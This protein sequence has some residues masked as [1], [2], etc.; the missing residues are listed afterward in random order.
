MHVQIIRKKQSDAGFMHALQ[1]RV[2]AD[3][4]NESAL[5]ALPEILRLLGQ[6]GLNTY[7]IHF[8][9]NQYGRFDIEISS[10]Y[11]V[12]EA[13]LLSLD[14]RKK[15]GRLHRLFYERAEDATELMDYDDFIH[16]LSIYT[17]QNISLDDKTLFGYAVRWYGLLETYQ[18]LHLE[19]VDT[20][21]VYHQI[22]KETDKHWISP[23]MSKKPC[24]FDKREFLEDQVVSGF[25]HFFLC[26]NYRPI[27]DSPFHMMIVP[28]AHDYDL[29]HATTEHLFELEALLRATLSLW[30]DDLTGLFIYMQKHAQSGMT[31]PHMHIHVLSPSKNKPFREDIVQQLQYF[32]ALLGEREEEAH[33]LA[34]SPLTIEVMKQKIWRF[35]WPIKKALARELR[36]QQQYTSKLYCGPYKKMKRE[37]K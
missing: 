12:V 34:R 24:P 11:P 21:D 23:A 29:S 10:E 15:V 2:M 25:D 13:S 27:G 16:E 7:A 18:F 37:G 26:L 31:V 28:Y 3:R 32:A 22:L 30:P 33:A 4:E 9:L 1:F 14:L 6:K 20:S 35:E 8:I 5:H 19:T 36:V 17:P